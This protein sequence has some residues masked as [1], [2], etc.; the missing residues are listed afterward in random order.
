MSDERITGFVAEVELSVR[1][2]D[3]E[4]ADRRLVKVGAIEAKIPKEVR[5]YLK[6]LLPKEG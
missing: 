6:S 1:D 2:K 4:I 3:G 5:A